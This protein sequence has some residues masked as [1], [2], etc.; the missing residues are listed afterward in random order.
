MSKF[1]IFPGIG[2]S[3]PEHWQSLWE[4]SGIDAV[5]VPQRDWNYPVCSE[6]V[7][8]LED[9]VIEAGDSA[10]IVAHSLACITIAHWASARHTKIKAAFLVA[11]PNPDGSHFPDAAVG[12]SP[13]PIT[14]FNFPSMVVASTNDPYS[15]IEF[16]EQCASNWGSKLVNIGDAGHINISSGFGA[17]SD[18]FKLLEQL[19]R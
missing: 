14:K 1:I 2:N 4:K 18:G 13:L 9:T 5:R 6:W 19:S 17:W 12:F 7:D 11:P 10:V 15:S 3:G 8:V 16:S